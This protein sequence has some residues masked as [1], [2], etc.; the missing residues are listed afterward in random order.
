MLARAMSK[1]LTRPIVPQTTR[2][3]SR[4]A[5][6]PHCDAQAAR[7]PPRAK[8]EPT[9]RSMPPVMMTRVM[10]SATIARNDAWTV[11]PRALSRL[12]NVG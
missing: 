2:G 9:E 10:P 6:K 4:A 7:T 8:T 1:P 5:K 12:A 11:T 3:T